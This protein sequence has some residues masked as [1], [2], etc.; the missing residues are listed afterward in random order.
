MSLNTTLMWT[1][2][3][4]IITILVFAIIYK[5]YYIYNLTQMVRQIHPHGDAENNFSNIEEFAVFGNADSEL[6]K[7][8]NTTITGSKITKMNL[9]EKLPI[10]EYCI[11]ASYNSACSGTYIGTDV[12]KYVLSRGCRYLDLEVYLV[13]NVPYVGFSTNKSNTHQNITTSTTITLNDALTT[14]N[15]FGFSSPSPNPTDPLFI[16]IR[17][18][19]CGDDPITSGMYKYVAGD[20][21]NTLSP[22]L[23]NKKITGDT[24]ISEI[25]NKIVIVIDVKSSSTYNKEPLLEKLVNMESGG[26]T[27]RTEIYSQMERYTISP[28]VIEKDG[29]SN[30]VFFREVHPGGVDNTDGKSNPD[31]S[32]FIKDFGVQI[33]TNR[34]Y[35][36]DV[37]LKE[38]EAFFDKFETAF[39]PFNR[40]I[41]FVK[42][43][44]E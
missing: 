30:V 18:Q 15:V 27:L 28:P 5:A 14:I 2:I 22:K 16:N 10:K 29:I 43:N 39:V 6:K 37:C 3:A 26:N 21:M 1:I 44:Y 41:S 13:D 4:S 17:M 40:A 19:S 32:K 33:I 12:L 24:S 11:K 31:Y 35:I 9:T 7:M 23:L 34:F 36:N 38:Y 8:N 42:D 25:M 20:I